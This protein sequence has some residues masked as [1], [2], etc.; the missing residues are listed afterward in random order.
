MIGQGL[1]ATLLLN[2]KG[3]ANIGYSTSQTRKMHLD[4][5]KILLGKGVHRNSKVG[6]ANIDKIKSFCKIIYKKL[7]KGEGLRTVGPPPSL[8][9]YGTP[10]LLG[11]GR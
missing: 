9:L 6:G 7:K 8:P 11:K 2:T 1:L 5:Y 10:M 3:D 4:T